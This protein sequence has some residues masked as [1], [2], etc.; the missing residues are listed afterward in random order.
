[1]INVQWNICLQFWQGNG[2]IITNFLIRKLTAFRATS[3]NNTRTS[4][5]VYLF[6]FKVYFCMHVFQHWI[7]DCQFGLSIW[8]NNKVG[9][10][11]V[12]AVLTKLDQYRVS[13]H[14]RYIVWYGKLFKEPDYRALRWPSFV[15]CTEW[16][17]YKSKKNIRGWFILLTIL[18]TSILISTHCTISQPYR[19]PFR[20]VS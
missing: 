5:T 9:S 11:N 3:L 16:Q 7:Y 13:Y 10:S 15:H 14:N 8:T 18:K 20:Y 19:S 12:N 1:M 17:S 6:S 4:F 2:I